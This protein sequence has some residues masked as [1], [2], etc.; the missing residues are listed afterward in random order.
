[1]KD[2]CEQWAR[3]D[4]FS[5]GTR[6]L[7]WHGAKMLTGASHTWLNESDPL[8]LSQ[9]PAAPGFNGERT[10]WAAGASGPTP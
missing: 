6:L 1:M 9:V 7:T 8:G 3:S 5:S 10:S 2:Q 4:W